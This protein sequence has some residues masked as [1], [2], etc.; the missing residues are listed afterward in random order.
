MASL[1]KTIL[2]AAK[3]AVAAALTGRNYAS[4]NIRIRRRPTL[5]GIADG[6]KAILSQSPERYVG[7]EAT[8]EQDDVGYGVLV[9][10]AQAGATNPEYTDAF[11]DLL[12][13]REALRNYFHNNPAA[14]SATM[15]SGKY[16]Y[17]LK[18]EPGPMLIAEHHLS[19]VDATAL[20]LRVL[21][22]ETHG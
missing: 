20:V 2:D 9:T 5:E 14:L 10:L 22:R 17:G 4:D 21:V 7:D 6:K 1:Q 13:D 8:N 12:E 11:D 19:G 15:P 3:T 18:V 16:Y